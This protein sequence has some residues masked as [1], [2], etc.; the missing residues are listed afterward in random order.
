MNATLSSEIARLT[1]G[2]KLAL[3]EELWDELSANEN[4]IPIPAW[5]KNALAED[6]A[7]YDA[8]PTEGAEWDEVKARITRKP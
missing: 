5:H 6:Q 1:A 8:N 4:V 7:R 3:M 2:E